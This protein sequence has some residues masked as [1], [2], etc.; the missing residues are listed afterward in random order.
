MEYPFKGLVQSSIQLHPEGPL[1][2]P[3]HNSPGIPTIQ[4]A[5]VVFVHR[6]PRDACRR[7][8]RAGVAIALARY[9]CP[10]ALW[11]MSDDSERHCEK[12]RRIVIGRGD[13]NGIRRIRGDADRPV[14][15]LQRASGK[16][17]GERA[18]NVPRL[19]A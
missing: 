4:H 9:L 11:P 3:I 16:R 13:G 5:N 2:S 12:R 7:S 8:R 6:L 18:G 19:T 14:Q 17:G 15:V 10:L 1:F